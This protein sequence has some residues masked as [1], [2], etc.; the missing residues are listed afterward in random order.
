VVA[1]YGGDEFCVLFLP[2]IQVTDAEQVG[3]RLRVRVQEHQLPHVTSRPIMHNAFAEKAHVSYITVSVGIGIT[4]LLPWDE[5]AELFKRA[6]EAMFDVKRHGGN[7]VC[8]YDGRFFRPY[9]QPG[10]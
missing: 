6:D 1:R 2:Q 7:D 9:G 4:F 5:S 8:T 3:E 10:P